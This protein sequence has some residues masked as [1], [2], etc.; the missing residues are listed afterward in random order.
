MR[1]CVPSTSDKTHGNR[2]RKGVVKQ[3]SLTLVKKTGG[4]SGGRKRG[5][6]KK[7]DKLSYRTNSGVLLD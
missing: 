7:Q 2:K 4:E 5:G 1:G 6:G 3:S